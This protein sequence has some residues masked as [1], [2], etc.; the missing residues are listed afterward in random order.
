MKGE[1]DGQTATVP[2]SPKLRVNY[3]AKICGA[4]VVASNP[5]MENANHMLT[6]NKDEYMLNLCSARKW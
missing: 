3:A 4:K 5:E 2:A 6:S 1:A